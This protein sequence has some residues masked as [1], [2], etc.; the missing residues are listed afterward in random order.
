M[1]LFIRGIM[2]NKFLKWIEVAP[3]TNLRILSTLVLAVG[4]AIRYW[5]ASGA[6]DTWEPSWE[7][8]TFLAAMA[9]I[10]VVQHYNKRKTSWR[11]GVIQK[12]EITVDE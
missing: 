2:K 11:P 5:I 1:I 8:L 10:D 6:T 12:D 4:T 3:T 9:G 7:W